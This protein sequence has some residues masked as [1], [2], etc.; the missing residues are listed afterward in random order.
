[1]K[2]KLSVTQR[3]RVVKMTFESVVVFLKK[4]P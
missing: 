1:M 4:Y 3:T 2:A